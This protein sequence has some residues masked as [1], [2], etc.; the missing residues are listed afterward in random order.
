[1][2]LLMLGTYGGGDKQAG[3]SGKTPYKQRIQP[4]KNVHVAPAVSCCSC[5]SDPVCPLEWSPSIPM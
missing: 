4:G 3:Q 5:G 2:A 1:M